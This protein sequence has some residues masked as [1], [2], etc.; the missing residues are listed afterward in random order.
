MSSTEDEQISRKG[1]I[2]T[3]IITRAQQ[4][5]HQA[6]AEYLEARQISEDVP[7]PIHH[8]L[9]AAV[10]ELYQAL[11]PL[12]EHNAVEEFWNSVEICDIH[13]GWDPVVKNGRVVDY[14]PVFETLTGFESL[15]ELTAKRTSQTI[16]IS[17]SFGEREVE[18]ADR[19]LV[20]EQ[21]LLKASQAL[22][23]A[24]NKLGFGPDIDESTPRTKIDDE[25]MEKVEKWRQENLE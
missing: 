21:V 9:Q 5:N 8:E 16:T 12:R 3:R 23:D 17:D 18:T 6:R 25:L 24:A 19:D 14:D 7:W 15:E 2:A 1:A 10:M 22:D 11:R 13:S 20:D 4:R